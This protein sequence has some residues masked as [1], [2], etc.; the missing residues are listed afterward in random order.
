MP[1]FIDIVKGQAVSIANQGLQKA[2]GNLPGVIGSALN[3]GEPTNNDAMRPSLDPKAFTF[4]LDVTNP[5]QGLGN[6][7]H[8]MIFFINEQQNAKISFGRRQASGRGFSNLLKQKAEQGISDF[9]NVATDTISSSGVGQ[10]FQKITNKLGLD[11][12][13]DGFSQSI[14]E[15]TINPND[16]R[17]R[18]KSNLEQSNNTA[19]VVRPPTTRLDTA[20]ALYMPPTLN[21][22]YTANYT[23]TEVGS[24]AVAAQKTIKAAISGGARG[25]V[26]AALSDE[27]QRDV[28]EGLKKAALGAVG[29]VPGLQGAREVFE[30]EQGFIMTNRMELMFKGLPKRGFQYTFKMIPKSELEADEIKNIVDAFKLNMLPEGLETASDG[31]TGKNLKI[32]NTFDIKYMYIG[33]ENEYLHKISTCVLESMNVSYGGDRFKAFDG[34]SRGAPPV[35]TTMTLN[36]KEMELIT[37]QRAAEGF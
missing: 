23:D 9:I 25:F 19:R 4:P 28:A 8:Y 5:D 17:G 7:G 36:F 1:A 2:L 32:P 26:G 37:R 11:S 21:V 16:L 35:E 20:I 12:L 6:H 10:E 27:V 3:R 13:I 34:N 29:A 24:G 33:K 18:G 31:F 22:S 14:G 30:L 15:S